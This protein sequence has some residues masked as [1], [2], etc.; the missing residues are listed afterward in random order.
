MRVV[1]ILYRTS[2]EV[3][4]VNISNQCVNQ[5]N[6]CGVHPGSPRGGCYDE[7]GYSTSILCEE[8]QVLRVL[9]FRVRAR[10]VDVGK[11]RGRG[12][13]VETLEQGELSALFSHR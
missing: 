5:V 2:H 10:V 3:L 7:V 13:R 6:R 8:V 9:E 12:R 1:F 4:Y 11:P